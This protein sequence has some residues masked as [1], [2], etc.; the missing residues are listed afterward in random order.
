MTIRYLFDI[1]GTHIR[2]AFFLNGNIYGLKK[3]K[4]NFKSLNEVLNKIVTYID[5]NR[6]S[7]RYGN[8]TAVI[9][10]AGIVENNIIISS[11]NLSFLNGCM[12]PNIINE[13]PIVAINDADSCLLGEMVY[14]K[15]SNEKNTLSLIFGTGIGSGLFING[16]LLPN[17]EVDGLFETYMAGKVFDEIYIEKIYELFKINIENL[18]EFLNIDVIIINGFINDYKIFKKIKN[19]INVRPYF[20]NKLNIIFS[21][22]DEPV[23]KGCCSKYFNFDN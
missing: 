7:L 22:A 5:N 8:G 19:K 21:K 20:K 12:I 1:G 11:T 10:I 16:K 6:F 13:T 18:V 3:E 15:V 14:N 23:I 2:T 17:S 9:A 4:H